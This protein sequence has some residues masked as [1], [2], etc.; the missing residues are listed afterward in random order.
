MEKQDKL[1]QLKEQLR[2][3]EENYQNAVKQKKDYNTLKAIRNA[4]SSLKNELQKL[5]DNGLPNQY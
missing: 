1:Y 5:L 2:K 4:I 3:E